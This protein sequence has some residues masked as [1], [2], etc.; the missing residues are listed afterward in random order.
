M[1]ITLER[2][3]LETAETHDGAELFFSQVDVENAFYQHGLP[4]LL[5]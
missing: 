3:P 1:P 4:G 5:S 2:I